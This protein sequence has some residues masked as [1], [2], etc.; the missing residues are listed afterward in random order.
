VQ[1]KRQQMKQK[2]PQIALFN[3]ANEPIT[4]LTL[5][6]LIA[7]NK[8]R[9]EHSFNGALSYDKLAHYIR[10]NKISGVII[11]EAT[12][13]KTNCSGGRIL[14]IKDFPVINV[15]SQPRFT[16]PEAVFFTSSETPPG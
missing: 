12:A 6:K 10:E 9:T 1:S 11:H 15:F 14:N 16:P 8:G 5:Y 13:V 4:D 2:A 7:I 3:E